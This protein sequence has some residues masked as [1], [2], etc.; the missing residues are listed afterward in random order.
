[1]NIYLFPNKSKK[2]IYNKYEENYL[3]GTIGPQVDRLKGGK[4]KKDLNQALVGERIKM[5]WTKNKKW[6]KGTVVGY[7]TKEQRHEV[8]Y[9][10][11]KNKGIKNPTLLETLTGDHKEW[12][13]I[14]GDE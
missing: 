1:M 2:Y 13:R 8:L 7:N 3:V 14:I 12:F 11:Y 4:P 6:Y 5:Y 9:D 10:R